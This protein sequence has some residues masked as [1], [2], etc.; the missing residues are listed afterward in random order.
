MARDPARSG[1]SRCGGRPSQATPPGIA[2]RQR[3]QFTSGVPAGDTA[4][5]PETDG[6]AHPV[7]ASLTA[8]C[9]RVTAGSITNPTST[10]LPTTWPVAGVGLPA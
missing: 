8:N 10:T 9:A 1:R 6:Q 7:A 3:R 5:L 2:P 4:G